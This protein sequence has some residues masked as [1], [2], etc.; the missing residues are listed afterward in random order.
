MQ[1]DQHVAVI[2]K[3]ATP[4]GK[5]VNIIEII[6]HRNYLTFFYWNSACSLESYKCLQIHGGC[7][8]FVNKQVITLM[9]LLNDSLNCIN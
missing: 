2:D 6:Y 9:R 4:L 5:T 1:F 7:Y 3:A 8:C